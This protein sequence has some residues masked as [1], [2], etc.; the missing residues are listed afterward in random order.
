MSPAWNFLYLQSYG[1]YL[2]IMGSGSY[3]EAVG[4]WSLRNTL[5]FLYP[6]SFICPF[7]LCTPCH[8]NRFGPSPH[9]VRRTRGGGGGAQQTDMHAT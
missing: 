3:D 6:V 4:K 5:P 2:L 9:V 7:L 8:P 1:L